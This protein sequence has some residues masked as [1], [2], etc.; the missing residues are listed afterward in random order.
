MR[1]QH[2]VTELACRKRTDAGMLLIVVISSHRE[3]R[4]INWVYSFLQYITWHSSLGRSLNTGTWTPV[5]LL[6]WCCLECTR[7]TKGQ[8]T[9]NSNMCLVLVHCFFFLTWYYKGSQ[10]C[11][12][13]LTWYKT[14]GF[15]TG[16]VVK[17][18]NTFGN[19]ELFG[20]GGPLKQ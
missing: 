14:M 7:C 6:W 16:S 15:L 18:I 5:L 10:T 8:L 1:K 17:V 12:N 19:S 2:L 11:S 20:H 4:K 9:S 13:S 3:T